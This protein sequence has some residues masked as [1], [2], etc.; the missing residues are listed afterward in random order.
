MVG[1]LHLSFINLEQGGLSEILP[2]VMIFLGN[3]VTEGNISPNP[4]SYK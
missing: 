2:E 1:D 4:P 3:I